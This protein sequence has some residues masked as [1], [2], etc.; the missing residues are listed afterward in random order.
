LY[1]QASPEVTKYLEKLFNTWD[2]W[3]QNR[4][5]YLR[6]LLPELKEHPERGTSE[7][8]ALILEIQCQATPE[9]WEHL[10]AIAESYT[11]QKK[12]I[13]EITQTLDRL[14]DKN[15]F[16]GAEA[17]ISSNGGSA[18]QSVYETKKRNA[19]GRVFRAATNVLER[20]EFEKAEMEIISIKP[21]LSEFELADYRKLETLLRQRYTEQTITEIKEACGEYN[22]NR[23]EALYA[24]IAN[25]YPR[26]AFDKMVQKAKQRQEREKRARLIKPIVREIELL[27]E[28]YD[29]ADAEQKY[30]LVKEDY[31]LET[32]TQLVE[33]CRQR[34]ARENL[35]ES[36]HKTLAAGSYAAADKT[37]QASGLISEKV[38]L[39]MKRPYIRKFVQKKYSK[40]INPEKA[41][42]LGSTSPNLLLSARAGSGKTTV[43]ACK[44]SML[45]D[46]YQVHPDHILV[47][48]FNRSAAEEIRNRIR[49]DYRQP[50]F[51]N[52][53]TFHSLAH[54][55]VQPTEELLFDEK[56]QIITQKMTLFVQQLLKEQIRNPVF[57]EK[58]YSFFRKEMREIERAG[59]LLDDE[60]YFDFRRN[61]LQVTLNGERVKSA[62]EKM[63]AD[64]LFEHEISYGYEKVWLWGSQI[65]RPDFSIYEQQKDYVIEHWGI[66]ENDPHK[67]VPPEW[68]QTW[69]EY[70]A[71]MQAKRAFWEEKSA[72]LVETSILDLRNG[73]EAFEA[74]LEERLAVAGIHKPMLTAAELLQKVRERDYTITRIAGLFTQFIQRAKKQILKPED[75]QNL[76]MSYQ[77]NDE[78]EA[79]F[80]NLAIRVYMEYEAA[81][82]KQHKIDFDDLMIRAIEHIHETEGEC[83]V[84][85]GSSKNRSIRLN[86]LRWILIDEYQDFSELF[87]RLITAIKKYNP[88]VQLFC[89]G[90]DW[91]AING[92][93]GSDLQFFHEFKNWLEEAQVAYLLTNFRSQA[94]I[95]RSGNALMEGL[96]RPG[97]PLP[98]NSHGEVTIEY[99]DDVWVELRSDDASVRQKTED[100]RF[101]ITRTSSS[102]SGKETNR[103]I[104]S[105]YLKKC[106]QIIT[107]PENQ[108]KSVAIL[109]RTNWIDGV[110][111]TEFKNR[112]ISC[113]S[114]ADL[115]AFSDP[116]TMIDVQT[117]HK[118]KGLEADLVIILG[119]C[120]GSFP[121]LH[122]DN[123]LFE[124][125][126]KT[127]QDAF[128]EERR[129]FYVALTRAKSSLYILTEKDR[130]SV[131]LK[132]L[133]AKRPASTGNR[134]LARTSQ[135]ATANFNAAGEDIPF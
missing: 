11:R 15:D 121:L 32:Y 27:L 6:T 55:L 94:E 23:V 58:M 8:K 65:Y 91:Q 93:A 85:L 4:S 68:N 89:V 79:E 117:A 30:A 110:K 42:A 111:L 130:E 70:H 82:E 119:A 9:E 57:I 113:F 24:R 28:K 100:E 67:Q 123:A 31:P 127:L 77:T 118:Y 84:L 62:G 72:V 78:R 114:A 16:A 60:A 40:S 103:I 98:Q 107:S 37:Y 101:L 74:I 108:G 12:R 14:F 43:L 13:Q 129:L 122:P 19:I 132:N 90:D 134:W 135:Y 47:M 128:E 105:K 96:G 120:N 25:S 106:Y 66:D 45:I 10:E 48:A 41:E 38:Y 71:K 22:F 2:E 126:G 69:D 56:D 3:D 76:L 21:H 73:R 34:Q 104:A 131:F 125:F 59:F 99:M 95:I 102:G 46:C 20:F 44:T 133:P 86:D 92:F 83:S 50:N 87:Y 112:L 53:R 63:I 7:E 5:Y 81:L 51:E 33:A 54:Q 97:Q 26:D 36:L 61:L 1:T 39:R 80:L 75:I 116:K 115:E 64:Y 124:I 29:F 88:Q 109:T 18:A 49:R 17:F 35:V 52:A